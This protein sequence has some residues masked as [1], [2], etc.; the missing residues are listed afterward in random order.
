MLL[1]LNHRFQLAIILTII[2]TYV[3][4]YACVQSC[5][6]TA[7]NKLVIDFWTRDL[8]PLSGPTRILLYSGIFMIAYFSYLARPVLGDSPLQAVELYD[9]TLKQ[10]FSYEGAMKLLP[11]KFLSLNKLKFIRGILV[12]GFAFCV[13][14]LG[15]TIGPIMVGI[16]MLFL[17]GVVQGCIGTSHRWYV[18]VYSSLALIFANANNNHYSLDYYLAHQYP[19]LW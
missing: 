1:P 4:Y 15:G 3:G 7:V 11:N 2:C 19:D 18:P 10:F 13:L 16:S 5:G 6:F 8:P 9:Y 14:G 17:H 12:V